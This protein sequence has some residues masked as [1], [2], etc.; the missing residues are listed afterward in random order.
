MRQKASSLEL[1]LPEFPYGSI[2]LVGAGDGD[3]CHLS[4]LAVHALGTADAV[5]HDLPVPRKLLDLANRPT[6][7]KRAHVAGRLDRRS[8]WLRTAGGS[9]VSS[10]AV[11]AD[12]ACA[13]FRLRKTSFSQPDLPDD[14]PGVNEDHSSVGQ[15]VPCEALEQRIRRRLGLKIAS[16]W[17]ATFR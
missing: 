11:R 3:A 12:F 1:E 6:L 7:A 9:C 13:K 2:W 15:D 16:R 4:P 17:T 14:Q 5:I 8:I 10:K